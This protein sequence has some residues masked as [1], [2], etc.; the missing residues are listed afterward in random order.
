MGPDVFYVRQRPVTDYRDLARQTLPSVEGVWTG[1]DCQHIVHRYPSIKTSKQR[2]SGFLVAPWLYVLI[3]PVDL[4]I[5]PFI[6]ALNDLKKL[7]VLASR[8]LSMRIW[9]AKDWH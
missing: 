3:F 2:R 7:L 9:D 8:N 5:I 6:G 1:Q 4:S